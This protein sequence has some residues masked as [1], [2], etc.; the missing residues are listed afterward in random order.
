MYSLRDHVKEDHYDTVG[1]GKNK[2]K[3]V[4]L[5]GIDCIDFRGNDDHYTLV[6]SET[7]LLEAIKR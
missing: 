1:L 5:H 3:W 4:F 2:T 6:S 7:P